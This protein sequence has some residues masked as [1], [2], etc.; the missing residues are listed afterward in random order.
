MKTITNIGYLCVTSIVG[1]CDK[2]CSI[3]PSKYQSI[4]D[5]NIYYIMFQ[6]FLSTVI[7]VLLWSIRSDSISLHFVTGTVRYQAIALKVDRSST[8]PHFFFG[9]CDSTFN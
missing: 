4:S 3:D 7:F 1:S 8:K 5:G 6:A 2:E 9:F